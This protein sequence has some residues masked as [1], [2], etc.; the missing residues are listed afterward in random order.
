MYKLEQL[1]EYDFHDSLLE[2][3]LYD[4]C[5]KKLLFKIDFCNWKQEW[6]NEAD[7]ET[8]MISIVFNNVSNIVLPE[9]QLNSDEIIEFEVLTENSIRVV[10]FNDIE[11]VS[12][13]IIIYAET[14]EIINCLW[15]M[16]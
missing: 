13:E 12:Y 7:E 5:N 2:D 1:T 14:V 16:F 15:F 4:E 6:Y 3:I 11:D 10:I 9:H 8:S